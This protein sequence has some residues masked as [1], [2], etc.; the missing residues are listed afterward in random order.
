MP[1]Q[2]P[3]IP[4][5]DCASAE[6]P[7]FL[8]EQIITYLGN[9]RSLLQF[10]TR[11]VLEVK[12]RLAKP[13]LTCFD[14]F[15]GSGIVSRA[16]KQH[17]SVLY[18]NDWESYSRI[19]NTCYLTNRSAVDME[20]LTHHLHDLRSRIAAEL[21]PGFITELYAPANDEHI[22]PGE[23]VFYT[24]RNAM[25][26]DT[27]RRLIELLPSRLRCF[28]LAPLLYG[29]S[30]HNN[31]SGVFKGFY[32][33]RHGIGQFGGDGRHALTRILGHIELCMPVFSRFDTECHIMQS[34]ASLALSAVPE[35]D[36]AYIDP[37]YNQ[38]PYGSNYFMLNL[39]ANYKRPKSISRVSGIPTDWNRS[40]YNKTATARDELFRLI[41]LCPAKYILIS[42]NSEGFIPCDAFISS[43]SALGKVD[44]LE[45]EYNTFR[46]C[47]NLHARNLKVKELLFL[48]ERN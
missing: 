25:Y 7:A 34:E 43:L 26:L 5:H 20:E 46:G 8:S 28:F 11:A 42:Y 12:R 39:V 32:K 16:L 9:K 15:A 21:R 27:A 29:A 2:Q 14:V 3:H 22:L 45:T 36:L 41:R 38:H 48:L 10:I 30:V 13:R 24:R 31:T 1:P 35:L 40:A 17:A 33:N 18:C 23:R 4:P 47:R 6:D 19:I 44:Y 37:P